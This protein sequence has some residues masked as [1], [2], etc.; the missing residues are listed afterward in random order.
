MS[1]NGSRGPLLMLCKIG[2][3]VGLEIFFFKVNGIAGFDG[4]NLLSELS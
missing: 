1:G 4:L 3:C 2:L